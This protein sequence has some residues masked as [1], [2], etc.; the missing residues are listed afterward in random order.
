[1]N[2]Q[3]REELAA[4]LL[5]YS[6]ADQSEVL[7]AYQDAAWSRFTHNAIH[8]NI[9]SAD[10]SATIRAIVDGRTGVAQTN[11]LDD[12]ELHGAARRASAMAR[13]APRD[14][15][16]PSLPGHASYEPPNGAYANATAS[17]SAHTRAE[18]CRRIFERAER[19]GCWPA[20][21]VM[22]SQ[23]GVT[24][25]N[26]IGVRASFDGT[27]AAISVKMNGA[28]STGFAEAY[29]P[30]V[31]TFDASAL[32]EAAARKVSASHEPRSV[33]PGEWTV[34][35]E[36]PA[37]GEFFSCMIGHFSAQAVDEGASFLCDGLERAYMGSN[38][39]IWDDYAH[40]L[41]PGMPFDFEGAPAR[42]IA[43]VRDGVAQAYVTDSY[44]AAK[45][46]VANTGH[47]L[48][49][50]NTA[51]PQPR[52]T[53]VEPGS[54]SID[55]LIAQTKIGLLVSRFW[56]LRPVDPRRTIIT[57][58]T[59]DGTFLIE[60]GRVTGGVRNLRFNQSVL[61]ALKSC[62]FSNAQTRTSSYA[63]STVVPAVKIERFRFTSETDF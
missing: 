40:P 1:L 14:P 56:Y 33:S 7:I 61:E 19:E 11:L 29:H 16:Q 17:A 10:V 21:Y 9:A 12:A 5:S 30:D 6:D 58:M 2:K 63:Y 25:A 50:P 37:F 43:L 57:G 52:H 46:Q 62:E 38:V 15:A 41:A 23:A 55:E 42:R 59:R 18:L 3:A 48:P 22:T 49:A 45:M 47:A 53:V 4:H 44:W 35:L 8:Q 13:L 36:P 24:V 20:G 54:K 31:S 51:G 60:D 34:I 27:D 26:S 39:T 28:D 32:A